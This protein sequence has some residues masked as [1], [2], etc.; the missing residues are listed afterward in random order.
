MCQATTAL[1]NDEDGNDNLDSVFLS[2]TEQDNYCYCNVSIKNIKTPVDL[3]INRLNNLTE[4]SLCGMEIDIYL[5]RRQQE[6]ILLQQIPTRCTSKEKTIRFS[7]FPFEYLHFTSRVVDGNFSIGYCIQIE[8]EHKQGDED[9]F[10]EISCDGPAVTTPIDTFTQPRSTLNDV[11]TSVQITPMLSFST[12]MIGH[13]YTTS[14]SALYIALGTVGGLIICVSLLVVILLCKRQLSIKEADPV[15]N[16]NIQYDSLSGSRNTLNYSTLNR[17]SEDID[18][19][20]YE[21]VNSNFI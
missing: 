7:L 1:E 11:T 3:Y 4:K 8:R 6:I 14:D 20:Q 16:R 21:I 10:L 17:T 18:E 9:S 12:A 5:V 15:D 19:Q 13:Q 2:I